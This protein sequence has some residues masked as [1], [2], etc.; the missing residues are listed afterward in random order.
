MLNGEE[1]HFQTHMDDGR[2]QFL[3]GC[4]T[5]SLSSLLVISWRPPSVPC[6]MGL[7]VALLTMWNL[8][9]QSQQ[10]RQSTVSKVDVMILC[11]VIMGG[12]IITFVLFYWLEASC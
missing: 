2:T 12:H 9:W 10:R 4:Q 7:T 1:I 11:Q 8:L 3:E 6:H 5:E